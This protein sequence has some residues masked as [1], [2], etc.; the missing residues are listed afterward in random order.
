MTTIIQARTWTSAVSVWLENQ[1][2]TCVCA[3]IFPHYRPDLV[4]QLAAATASTFCDYRKLKMA[5]LGWKAAN[6]TLDVLT[7]TAEDEMA[8]GRAVV[9]HNVEAMLSL[10]S[11]EAREAWFEEA[12]ARR[13]PHRLV[14][15]LTLYAHD[16]PASMIDHVHELQAEALPSDGILQRA[17]GLR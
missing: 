8:K 12:A 17:A 14:L 11:R 6:L 10:V 7:A 15:P 2:D 13:W 16:L 4:E 9:L 1:P 3:V 5:P